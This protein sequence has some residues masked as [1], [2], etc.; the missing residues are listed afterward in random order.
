MT[1]G[2][3]DT[4]FK[5]AEVADETIKYLHGLCQEALAGFPRTNRVD[6]VVTTRS[7]LEK[8]QRVNGGDTDPHEDYRMINPNEQQKA[9][10]MHLHLQ[11]RGIR[12]ASRASCHKSRRAEPQESL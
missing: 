2:L 11:S 7:K 3:V 6:R 9:M 12:P 4:R 1:Q 10:K 5:H 8:R